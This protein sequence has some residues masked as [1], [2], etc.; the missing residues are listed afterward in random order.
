M[1]TPQ[2]LAWIAPPAGVVKINVDAALSKNDLKASAIARDEN[3]C[4]LGASAMVLRGISDPEV[5]ESIAC[6]EGMSLALDIQVANFRFASDNQNVV[7]NI[8]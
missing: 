6:R 5:M 1:Y 3:G 2:G 4:F 7:K 8:L